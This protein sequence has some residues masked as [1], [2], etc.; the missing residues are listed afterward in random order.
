MRG[1]GGFHSS[2]RGAARGNGGGPGR[3][4]GFGSLRGGGSDRGGMSRNDRGGGFG[5]GSGEGRP[6]MGEGLSGGGGFGPD[7]KRPRMEAP[8]NKILLFTIINPLYPITTE[9]MNKICS[10]FGEVLRIVVFKKTGVQSMVE[11]ADLE[12]AKQAKLELEGADI[13]SNCCTLSIEYA[14]ADRLNVYKNDSE[15]WDYTTDFN[16][17]GFNGSGVSLF[18]QCSTEAVTVHVRRTNDAA[19]PYDLP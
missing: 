2:P 7:R 8:E 16:D 4:R 1:R 3:G 6:R 17:S 9:V 14:K 15:T 12:G 10:R 13:Y 18:P 19:K 11:F 5:M